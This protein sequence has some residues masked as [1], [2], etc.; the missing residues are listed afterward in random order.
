MNRTFICIG[1]RGTRILDENTIYAFVKALKYGAEYIEFDIRKTKDNKLVVI[2]DATIERTTSG[3]GLIK[4]FALM[5][6][7]LNNKRFYRKYN[8][9]SAG[10]FSQKDDG[11]FRKEFSR[12]FIEGPK[13]LLRLKRYN[14][15]IV[16]DFLKI[17]DFLK[18]D[19]KKIIDDFSN[20]PFARG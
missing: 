18:K 16:S 8:K 20:M 4:D 2:H 15:K 17:V 13:K 12:N 10:K 11:F 19:K 7:K 1:H 14:L 9:Y 6:N 3:E 5:Q